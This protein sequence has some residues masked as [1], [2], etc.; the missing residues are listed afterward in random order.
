MARKAS[1]LSYRSSL[2]RMKNSSLP[3]VGAPLLKEAGFETSAWDDSG[4]LLVVEA[5]DQE[6]CGRN[7][8]GMTC[9][10]ESSFTRLTFK[11][12][13]CFG[14]GPVLRVLLNNFTRSLDTPGSDAESFEGAQRGK[15]S[16]VAGG[17]GSRGLLL[18]SW[19]AA[20]VE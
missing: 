2:A 4:H 7:S 16:K 8:V 9:S 18:S 20:G 14:V 11:A 15:S 17:G 12:W 6:G 10:K 5:F 13:R 19:R 1:S 3:G